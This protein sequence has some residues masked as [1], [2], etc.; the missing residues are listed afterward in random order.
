MAS[1]RETKLYLGLKPI[2]ADLLPVAGWKELPIR[3]NHEPL[4]A[5]GSFSANDSI[6]A[7]SI[8]FGEKIDSPY[9][10]NAL[11]GSLITMFVRNEVAKQLKAAQALLPQGMHLI[12]FDTYRAL[13]VQQSLYDTYSQELRKLHPQWE[14]ERLTE[15]T[16]KYVSLPST[17]LTRPSP[18]N[19]GGSVDLAIYKL[20]EDI[21]KQVQDLD[22]ELERLGE[23]NWQQSYVL[24]MRKIALVEAN[25]RLLNFG[26]KFDHGGIEASLNYFEKLSQE[27]LLSEDEQEALTNRR[28]L[29]HVMTQA[30][31]E[32]YEEEWWH[33]NSKKSQMGA[34]TAGLKQAE[35]GAIQ[36][37]GENDKHELMRR[38][39][40]LGSIRIFRGE[41]TSKLGTIFTSNE[42]LI[43]AG[44]GVKETGDI[45]ATKSPLAAVIKPQ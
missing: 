12:V 29:Y 34:K 36:L 17:D 37:S 44:L 1:E 6:Y 22:R 38:M 14:E 10:S 4:V 35:Y 7:H 15:K 26:T 25:M 42:T 40:W 32:P 9:S 23:S 20:P 45:R 13:A 41:V 39:H 5:L 18:H 11:E 27:K 16:Q 8:Y 24:E 43:A 21:E 30:G 19:T 33:Y 28:I 2:P 3:E 31:F